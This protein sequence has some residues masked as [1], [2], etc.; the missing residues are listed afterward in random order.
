MERI[1][2][3]VELERTDGPADHVSMT[4]PPALTKGQRLNVPVEGGVHAEVIEVT[5]V[6]PPRNRSGG[7]CSPGNWGSRSRKAR[8]RLLSSMHR[9]MIDG[10]MWGRRPEGPL[11]HNLT[12]LDGRGSPGAVSGR[13]GGCR[14][15]PSR[16]ACAWYVAESTTSGNRRE[17]APPERARQGRHT[18]VGMTVVDRP[19]ISGQLLGRFHAFGLP[20]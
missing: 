3:E 2:Y 12:S 17:R 11:V 10:Q 4:L 14:N 7:N 20:Q 13:P 1:E 8:F 15:T 6:T 16:P 9:T 5:K 18:A 19:T